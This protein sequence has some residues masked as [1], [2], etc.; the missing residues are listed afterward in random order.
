MDRETLRDEMKIAGVWSMYDSRDKR[1]KAAFKL[2]E[3]ATGLKLDMSCGKCAQ[4]V[5]DFM[6]K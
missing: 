3:K 5:Q 6:K 2:Y 4:K 1:W